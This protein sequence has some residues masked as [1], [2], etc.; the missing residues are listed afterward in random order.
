MTL[1]VIVVSYNV[2]GYLSLCL[3]SAL[4]AMERLPS[5]TAEVFVFDNASSDGSADWVSSHY[6]S[7]HLI[8]SEENLGF[9][10][11]NNAA[12]RQSKGEWV[13]LLNPDTVV[14]EDTFEK[15]L[16]HAE[17]HP[18]VGAIGVPM[19]DGTGSWLPESKRGLPTPWASFCR[20]SGIW[21]LAPS[22]PS[23]NRYYWGHT[24]KDETAAV[25]VLSGAF[26][27]MRREAL[28]QAGLLDEDF[29]MY[30]EDIDLSIRIQDAG[31]VNHYFSDAPIVHFKGESTK[32][33]SL[34]YVRVFHDAMRIF[35]AK[36]FAGRQAVAMQL[37]I[38]VG[39]RVRAVTA[40]LQGRVRRH[41]LPLLDL[42]LAATVAVCV[43][44]GHAITSG[45]DH[46][47]MPSLSLAGLA[48][49]VSGFSGT[50]FGVWDRPFVR[51]RVLMAGLAAGLLLVLA[52]SLLP[53]VLRV[54]RMA[55]G[56]LALVLVLL[57]LGVRALLVTLMPKRFA[58]RRT[59]SS[60]G[61]IGSEERRSAMKN[62][63][64][65]SYGSSLYVSDLSLSC[66]S[67]IQVLSPENELVLCDASWGGRRVLDTVRAGHAHG[68]DVRIVPAGLWLALGGARK[69]SGPKDRLL[70]GEDGLCRPER[71][72]SKRRLDIAWSLWILL[73]GS[74]KGANAA[75]FTRGQAWSVLR[76]RRTWVGFHGSWDGADRLPA[77][78]TG[79][80]KVGSGVQSVSSDEAKRLD[81]RYAYDYS[82]MRDFEL[83]MT[84]R[85]D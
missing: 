77:L 15:V 54:S 59:R 14:P 10:A 43:I 38:E 36:H 12:I 65:S 9:S 16:A 21:R 45:I 80:F 53:E 51:L 30:G 46:P 31:W 39:I 37:M 5:G 34:A 73:V 20:L 44:R 78:E 58:W 66:G 69:K 67:E 25:E 55:M 76:S 47:W 35:S 32:K 84:L 7:V 50:W 57:P 6:P 70:W 68:V 26:M 1:S 4:A 27:W 52:Y 23:L 74:G 82:W 79:I 42:S 75:G 28:D 72:R 11:G 24:G 19:Y 83:L 60:V 61:F 63:I 85:M 64:E 48:V 18:E 33:G 71:M 2:K 3:D 8:R 56:L 40:F 17:A 13:L 81:L 29:F 41:A 62:W 49:G 22:S